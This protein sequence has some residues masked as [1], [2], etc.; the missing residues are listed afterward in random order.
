[1]N[2]LRQTVPLED[3]RGLDTGA[4]PLRPAS[5]VCDPSDMGAARATRHSFS[6][7]VIRHMVAE[8]W[9]VTREVFDMDDLGRGVAIYRIEAD[10]HTWRLVAF[11]QI[12]DDSQREDRVIA[13]GW[14]ITLALVQGD[15]DQ[16]RLQ[17]LRANVPLQENGRADEG[18]IIWARGNRSARFFD[19]VVNAL[20]AGQQPDP[21]MFEASPYVMR[22]TAFYSNGKFGLADFERF[23]PDHPFAVPYRP[24]FLSAWLMRELSLDLVEHCARA[25]NPDAAVLDPQWRRYFGLGNATG[26]GMVPYVIN[27]PQVLDAWAHLREV[28][29][30]VVRGRVVAPGDP[31]VARVRELFDR[32]VT[33]LEL[34]G[35][36]DITPF[37]NCAI[38]AGELAQVRE[39]LSEYAAH[40]TIRG[41]QVSRPWDVLHAEAEALSQGCRGAV[42]SIL[43]E[44]TEELDTTIEAS[45]SCD[46]GSAVL[47]WQSTGELLAT[48]EE[49]YGWVQEFDFTDPAQQNYFW[50][51]SENNEEPRRGRR[52][53][54]PGV[55]VEHGT[56]IART[57]AALR[58][59]L[60]ASDPSQSVARFLVAHPWHRGAVA[61]VQNVHPLTYGEVQTNLLAKDFLPLNVQRL[62]LCVYGMENFVP[63][64]TDWLRVT[65]FVGAPRLRD[66]AEG[67][68]DD[69][70]IFVSAPG[71][72]ARLEASR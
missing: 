14:D 3:A 29:L 70:W 6:R 27:H 1:M 63:Q 20:A 55:S 45:L 39:L 4:V 40:G 9:R 46:E 15:V 16:E 30:A 50:F 47:P 8:Q 68:A 10:P 52:G 32:A 56:D 59:D 12:L 53:V 26:L 17:S 48:I 51:S 54:D 31:D 13:A 58:T 57:V 21:D 24:H 37:P 67:S 35:S 69:D 65:L 61:R 44:L 28:P 33:Y 11:S 66:L 25:I 5:Q 62:Q 49:H 64:S 7:S 60:E 18:T 72:A 71:T 41:T 22:S 42:A 19:A 23:G 36:T 34:G 2:T 38:I 43:V